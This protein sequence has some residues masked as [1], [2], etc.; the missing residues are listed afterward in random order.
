MTSRRNRIRAGLANLSV[1]VV[2]VLLALAAE[3]TWAE[4]GDRIREQ[5]VLLDLLEDFREN[6]ARLL[7]DI[8][9]NRV[10]KDAARAWASAT[11]GQASISADSAH[12]LLVAAH[13]DAR[14]DPITGALR[15]LLDGG[16]LRVIEDQGLRQAL[17]GWPDRTEEAQLTARSYDDQRQRLVSLVL[18][19]PPAESLT[20]RRRS[21]V[22][23]FAEFTAGHQS[24]LEA[25]A[26]T[27]EEI[28]ALLNQQIGR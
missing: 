21:A 13:G 1:I 20:P 28:I 3:A 12:T 18:S 27:V 4:R 8:E 16:E 19:F 11:L 6:Q 22:L 14:F 25:L 10:A 7:S 24:Q 23:L 5:E 15:S 9:D 17:A 2:G 26:E